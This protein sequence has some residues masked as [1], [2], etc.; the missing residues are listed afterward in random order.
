MQQLL[1]IGD[2]G[3]ITICHINLFLRSIQ[4]VVC[5]ILIT[6]QMLMESSNRVELRISR[7]K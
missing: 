2:S 4:I 6:I 7:I 5:S 1:T 3:L